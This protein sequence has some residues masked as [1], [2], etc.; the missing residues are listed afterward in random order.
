MTSSWTQVHI[1]GLS[2]SIYPTD[3][4]IDSMLEKKY[5]LSSLSSSASIKD[6]RD[7]DKKKP[8]LQSSSLC[9]GW[10]GT[11][12]TIVKRDGEGKCRGFA[13]VSFHSYESASIFID[14]MNNSNSNN[15]TIIE[16]EHALDGCSALPLGIHAEMS[17]PGNKAKRDGSRNKKTEDSNYLPDL[18]LR[19][20]RKQPVRK[21]P[22]ITS[23]NGKRTNLSNSNKAG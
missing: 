13:F 22:V 14:R 12:T 5:Q 16:H 1:T 10:A 19:R 6:G 2:R 18:R 17:I 3:E 15:K 9:C 7:E 20:Q 8:K 11:G 21:H 23:S 4:E